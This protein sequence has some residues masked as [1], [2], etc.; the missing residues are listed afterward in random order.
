[1]LLGHSSTK[2]TERH[3]LPWVKRRQAKLD[4]AVDRSLAAQGIVETTGLQIQ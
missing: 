2:T 1:M 3:Y 4:A